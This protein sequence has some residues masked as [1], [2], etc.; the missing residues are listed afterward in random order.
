MIPEDSSHRLFH[1][2]IDDTDMV[3]CCSTKTPIESI[4]KEATAVGL[5]FPL[6]WDEKES[7]ANHVAQTEFAPQSSRFGPF[8]DNILGMNW[9]LNSGKVIRIGERVIKSTTGYDLMRFLLHSDGRYGKAIDYVFRLRPNTGFQQTVLFKGPFQTIETVERLLVRSSWSQ[10]LDS[11]E[12]VIEGSDGDQSHLRIQLNCSQN[13]ECVFLNLFHRLS[14]QSGAQ[15]S[16]TSSSHNGPIPIL[17]I[18][19][20]IIQAPIIANEL[21]KKYGG[22]A[23][24]SSLNGI[25]FYCHSEWKD[26]HSF[27]YLDQLARECAKEGGHLFGPLSPRV[28]PGKLETNWC[29][30]LENTWNQL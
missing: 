3:M 9:K 5:R 12:L 8:V 15:M 1:S 2:F 27:D 7:I 14:K 18:K 13:E 20:T 29:E 21:V 19:T 4:N 22:T 24:I 25:V 30:I 16:H 6:L 26:L 11:I 28:N 23:R 10:W 17:S